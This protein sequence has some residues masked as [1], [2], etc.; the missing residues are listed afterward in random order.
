M[1]ITSISSLISGTVPSGFYSEKERPERMVSDHTYAAFNQPAK[2]IVISNNIIRECKIILLQCNALTMNSVIELVTP[3]TIVGSNNIILECKI[4]I[5]NE[6]RT[7][8]GQV[9]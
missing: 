7:A 5:Q 3:H 9:K 8:L 2:T 1:V 6:Y 4:I